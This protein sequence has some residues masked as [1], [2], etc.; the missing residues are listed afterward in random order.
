M[1]SI[2]NCANKDYP[3][4]TTTSTHTCCMEA[5]SMLSE[6]ALIEGLMADTSA[7]TSILL[8]QITGC[9]LRYNQ[10]LSAT[11]GK[12]R[13]KIIMQTGQK[14]LFLISYQTPC[15]RMQDKQPYASPTSCLTKK[16]KGCE[17]PL[18]NQEHRID[19]GSRFTDSSE[20]KFYRLILI[21]QILSLIKETSFVKLK[22]Q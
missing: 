6:L 4:F 12:Q 22:I 17:V 10:L 8:Q 21:Q 9:P 16:Q 3:Q 15:F 19:C 20:V 1:S 2:G 14:F 7:A 18:S 11:P 13:G 5:T